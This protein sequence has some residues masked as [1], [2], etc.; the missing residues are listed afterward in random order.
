MFTSITIQK[1]NIAGFLTLSR[2][3]RA[4][5]L[6]ILLSYVPESQL[7]TEELKIYQQVDVEDLDLNLGS[8][9]NINHDHHKQNKASTSRIVSKPSQSVLTGYAFNV[10][11]SFIYSIQFRT[12]S[13]GYWYG[14]IVLNLQ[15]GENYQ[16]CFSMIMKVR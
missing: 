4:T 5:N 10:Q 1:D 6:E 11:L 14:S 2:P 15:D 12:P 9:N 16:Y 7:S 8:V 13:H 3:P